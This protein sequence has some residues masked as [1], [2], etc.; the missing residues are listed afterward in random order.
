MSSRDITL[1]DGL[2]DIGLS[3][4][5][6]AIDDYIISDV[7][8]SNTG[9]YVSGG[10]D[11]LGNAYTSRPILIVD[12]TVRAGGNATSVGGPVS[13]GRYQALISTQTDGTPNARSGG[14][15]TPGGTTANV[16]TDSSFRYAAFSGTKYYYGFQELGTGNNIVYARGGSS[17]SIWQNGT[18]RVS[19]SRISARVTQSSI[20]NAPTSFAVNAASIT[21]TGMQFTW[22]TP[23]DDGGDSC[24]IKGYRINY[25]ANAASLWSVLVANTGS[26]ATSATVSG[27]S[28]STSYDFQVAA[29]NDT[30]DLH[31]ASNYSSITAHVGVRSSTVTVSTIADHQLK[32]FVDGEFKKGVMKVWDGSEFK[33][34]ANTN[35]SVWTGSA[36]K[37]VKLT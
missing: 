2:S 9:T 1:G 24:E 20:P 22:T 11:S 17:G 5:T 23:T 13:N 28:P 12:V 26:T 31:S 21:P 33:T 3:F 37:N 7:T 25:K 34:V 29:L 15:N 19:S 14:A 35:I 36:F 18:L 16:S 8:T 6:S 4:F 30:T 27:L 10:F 32:V